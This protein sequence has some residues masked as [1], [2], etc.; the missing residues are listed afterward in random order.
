MKARGI[1][2]LQQKNTL[3]S[4]ADDQSIFSDVTAELATTE[5]RR[6]KCDSAVSETS[7]ATAPV[8]RKKRKTSPPKKYQ[9]SMTLPRK[10]PGKAKGGKS[11]AGRTANTSAVGNNDDPIVVDVDA[12]EDA[13]APAVVVDLMQ[14]AG[15]YDAIREKLNQS[16]DLNEKRI[17]GNT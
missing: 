9:P 17:G 3:K 8:G 1:C 5:T 16:T 2:L 4:K 11:S 15:L 7:A 12:K 14:K 13:K 6:N 10:K